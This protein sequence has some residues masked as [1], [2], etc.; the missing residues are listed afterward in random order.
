VIA[1]PSTA[2]EI[3]AWLLRASWQAAVLVGIVL[4]LGAVLGPRLR[5]RWRLA[6]WWIVVLRLV[7]P[8]I[9]LPWP[10]LSTPAAEPSRPPLLAGAAPASETA[11]DSRIEELAPGVAVDPDDRS[12]AA[13]PVAL[14]AE[15]PAAPVAEPAAPPTPVDPTPLLLA[16]WL[17]GAALLAAATIAREIRLVRRL[18]REPP[19]TDAAALGLVEE[20]RRLA[21]IRRAIAVVRS[22]LVRVPILTGLRRPRLVLPSAA[23]ERLAPE[24][25][26]H[27]V[28]HE[29][30]HV[31]RHDIA[32][33][34]ALH[35]CQ[36][37]YWFHPLVWLALARLRGDR[38]AARDLDVL[39]R[40]RRVAPRDYGRTIL[41]VVRMAGADGAPAT[42]VAV[43]ESR[44]DVKRRIAMIANHDGRRRGLVAG[45]LAAL[46]LL[47][48][49]VLAASEPVKKAPPPPTRPGVLVVGYATSG[50]LLEKESALA[51]NLEILTEAVLARRFQTVPV[52]PLEDACD[53]VGCT[54][55]ELRASPDARLAVS[56]ELGVRRCVTGWAVS[57]GERVVL[58]IEVIDPAKGLPGDVHRTTCDGVEAIPAALETLLAKITDPAPLPEEAGPDGD[59]EE[60][61]ESFEEPVRTEIKELLARIPEGDLPHLWAHPGFRRLDELRENPTQLRD[62]ERFEEMV[63]L[64][65]E[66]SEHLERLRKDRRYRAEWKH[67][68]N[69]RLDPTFEAFVH[70]VV[71]RPPFLLF[72]ERAKK[73]ERHPRADL[74]GWALEALYREFHRVIGEPLELPRL[75]T[76]PDPDDGILKGRMFASAASL[77]R[78]Q[79]LI[80]MPLP[81]SVRTY[82]NPTV[83]WIIAR[84]CEDDERFLVHEGVHALMHAYA[85]QAL[86]RK[87][88]K[89]VG[90]ED[91]RLRGQRTWLQEGL[92]ALFAGARMDARGPWGLGA[93][94]ERQLR[95]W[96]QIVPAVEAPW[97]L[98]EL[99][100]QGGRRD[101]LRTIRAK[102]T[103]PRETAMLEPLFHAQAWS[104]CFFLWNHDGGKHRPKLLERI[105]RELHG[106][107]PTGADTELAMLE[108]A[109]Q[110]SMS[111]LAR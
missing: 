103:D 18:G 76:L 90:W 33:N 43:L 54:V 58:V 60:T 83:R 4:L 14:P 71:S 74:Y 36:C 81:P 47:L 108:T 50:D 95:A 86:S 89:T 13:T 110:E 39:R 49:T 63:R 30:E 32:A 98:E 1:W 66:V 20:A 35:A 109:W 41:R 9:A 31:R 68:G 88:G 38:E 111:T 105:R 25:L 65:R 75:E 37:L 24:E 51:Q 26:R 34:W 77:D 21:G 53:E 29:M 67:R 82:Y 57:F 85:R 48:M 79:S 69:A 45:G 3:L 27:V 93:R 28:L 62:P 97:T 22:D 52:G 78:Y 10:E 84:S 11:P 80:R 16:L 61:D 59:E 92:A 40:H 44:R 94:N 23:L 107:G 55:G 96:K 12:P 70:D 56:K 6:L 102:T 100:G 42:S 46:A 99:L 91:P 15:A 87:L 104:F 73:G 72:V 106:E 5:P 17:L 2:A 64:I 101:L 8:P 7:L 19:L